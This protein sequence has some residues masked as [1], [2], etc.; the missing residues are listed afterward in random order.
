[1]VGVSDPRGA[2]TDGTLSTNGQTATLVPAQAIERIHF[3]SNPN[4]QLELTLFG[5]RSAEFVRP[6]AKFNATASLRFSGAKRIA[7][8]AYGK[9]TKLTLA[10]DWPNPSFNGGFLPRTRTVSAQ[11]FRG[12]WL[13]PFIA[14]GVRA[15]GPNSSL[16][17]L[18]ETAMGVSFVNLADPYQSVN[19]SLKYVLL[20]LGLLFLSYVMFKITTGKLVHPAQ[21]LL[22][23]IAQIIFYL[24]LLSLAEHIG[25]GLGFLIAG[26]ATV[27]L[28]SINASWI[29]ES[30]VQGMRALVV[31]SLLYTFIYLLLRLED[32]ALLVGA[33]ASFL[34]VGFAMYI[35]RKIDW[36]SSLH[37]NV[38]EEKSPFQAAA[39]RDVI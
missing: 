38:V 22:I 20:F 31:F 15:E 18:D 17:G 33:V 39:P 35:T 28:L 7:V 13:I 12:E 8:L 32:N 27:C 1:V 5:V 29:F 36:Y 4:Q 6:N 34:A 25:F 23:G 3:G 21:Y 19:R 11:G 30:R 26:A 14:R 9:T 10:S 24:L 2:L 16:G 37:S